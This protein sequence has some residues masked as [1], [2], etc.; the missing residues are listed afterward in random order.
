MEDA[1]IKSLILSKRNFIK[2]FT[3]DE[4][5][6]IKAAAA[7]NT[8]V[9]YYWQ[10]FM[11][12]EE[13]DLRNEDTIGGLRALEQMTLIGTGRADEIL[14]TVTPEPVIS[15]P[16]SIGV[17]LLENQITIISEGETP[18]ESYIKYWPLT[19]EVA[20]MIDSGGAQVRVNG[21]T[22]EVIKVLS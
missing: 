15:T 17:Y 10:L 12:A 21:D 18:P 6:A 8:T 13:V 20:A 3:V 9:D 16:A 5:A 2:R 19:P 4:Y 22:I 1:I 14:E 7:A 11:V